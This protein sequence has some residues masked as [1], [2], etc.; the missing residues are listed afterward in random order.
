MCHELGRRR[1]PLLQMS[2]PGFMP[3][4]WS[5]VAS[6]LPNFAHD[7]WVATAPSAWDSDPLSR[8]RPTGAHAEPALALSHDSNGIQ[9]GSIHLGHSIRPPWASS[10]ETGAPMWCTIRRPEPSTY[11]AW[12]VSL[13]R[14]A[15]NLVP[16]MRK[17]APS[18][19][20]YS[21]PDGSSIPSTRIRRSQTPSLQYMAGINLRFP[22]PPE[23]P[24]PINSPR[25]GWR[26]AL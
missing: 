7:S 9:T 5:Q 15:I 12:P 1:S 18:S 21:T 23:H 14:E 24:S 22:P 6:D 4:I 2:L 25:S 8:A 20:H 17:L 11:V 10:R 3:H 13:C 19:S 16:R 26:S